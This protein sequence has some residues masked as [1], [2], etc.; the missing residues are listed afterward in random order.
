[1]T[2]IVQGVGFRPHVYSLAVRLGL[3]G[4]VANDSGGVTIEVEGE[5][6]DEFEGELRAHPPPQALIDGWWSTVLPAC[7]ALGFAIHES[8]PPAEE[9]TPVS[10][11]LATCGECLA[12]LF[13]PANRRYRYPFLNCTNCGPRF[14]ITRSTPYDRPLTTMG[15]FRMCQACER[16]YHDP[17]DRRFHAQPNACPQCG[18]RLRFEPGGVEGEAALARALAM[19]AE[20]GIVAV[21]GIG[22]FHLACLA[23]DERAV[24][25]L[26]RRKGRAEKP[27]A[28]MMR[29][30]DVAR[31]YAHVDAVRWPREQPIVLYPRV[32]LDLPRLVA[33]G[34]ANLG[35]F[36][37]YSPLHRLLIGD[38]PLVMTS[39]NRSDEP[40]ARTNGEAQQRLRDLADGFLLHDREI[41]VVCDDSVLRGGIPVRRSR[42][43]APMPIR[44]RGDGP[45]VLAVGG[46][47]KATFCLTRGE[48]A[49]MSQHIG[50]M[51]NLETLE[52][53]ERCC[54]QMKALFRVTPDVVACDLHPGY[55]STRWAQQCGLP[56]VRVQHHHAHVA[57]LLTEAEVEGP[58]IGVA[59][60]GAG[61]GTDGAIWGGEIL[62]ADCAHFERLTHLKYV[63]LPG[64]D[65]GVRRPYRMA[66]AHLRSEGIA[67]DED[68]PC[69]RSAAVNER[70]IV[71]REL[72]AVNTS[73]VGR[74]FDAVASLI[75]LRHVVSYEGQAAM[76]LE[77]AADAGCEQSYEF[78]LEDPAPLWR[79]LIADGR[80]DETAGTMA[81]RFHNGLA[82]ATVAACQGRGVRTVALTGGVFQNALLLNRTRQALEAE[83]FHVLTHHRVPPNDGGI[84][85]GQAAAARLAN[86]VRQ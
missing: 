12:D 15:S 26:R 60:D 32:H 55:L 82:R 3:A 78:T 64:G 2:G 35:I 31:R 52:A 76:E 71:E 48:R 80:R 38:E 51:E 85:L 69:V 39:G 66:L 30:V 45:S 63:P 37:P 65:A 14:T 54:Q 6:L 4:F 61:Y 21:K 58:V 72:K 67:W 7:D 70:R 59:F 43:F 47:L 1:M 11:D 22:G 56:V 8:E 17:A 5:R 62:L 42:G 33:P 49:Y 86:F 81:A 18:P 44:L 19:L 34:Q 75:G 25:E 50:D 74:L 40:I 13:D 10:P 23:N 84:A 77:A 20:G 68:L 83:G 9:S 29:D 57:A 73:S 41:H 79:A 53:F 16:E 36:F 46:E 24:A 28:L 27:F